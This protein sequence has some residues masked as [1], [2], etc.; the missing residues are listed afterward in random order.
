MEEMILRF[1]ERK[2]MMRNFF[3]D[4]TVGECVVY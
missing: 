3:V 1:A 4:I 2:K